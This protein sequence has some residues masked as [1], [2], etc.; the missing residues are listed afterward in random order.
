MLLFSASVLARDY[1]FDGSMSE[2]VLRSYLS[3]SMTTMYLVEFDNYGRSRRPG[4]AG[5]GRFWVW[6]WDDYKLI[7]LAGE[8]KVAC[9]GWA[10]GF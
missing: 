8:W 2:E 10:A 1:R 7:G 5:Q 4:E 3:R 6:G 9:G